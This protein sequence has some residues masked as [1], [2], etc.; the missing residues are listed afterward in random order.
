MQYLT[1]KMFFDAMTALTADITTR[2]KTAIMLEGR[3]YSFPI[4]FS[5]LKDIFLGSMN[6]IILRMHALES[7]DIVS[8]FMMTFAMLSYHRIE[9]HRTGKTLVMNL[10]LR[11]VLFL[12]KRGRAG[13]LFV[14][15]PYCLWLQDTTE[16]PEEQVLKCALLRFLKIGSF[17]ITSKSEQVNYISLIRNYNQFWRRTL[18]NTSV[19]NFLPQETANLYLSSIVDIL[20]RTRGSTNWYKFLN[21]D[22]FAP[23]VEIHAETAAQY[24][25]EQLLE[26]LVAPLEKPKTENELI[27][28]LKDVHPALGGP[29][30]SLRTTRDP[31][32]ALRNFAQHVKNLPQSIRQRIPVIV[33]STLAKTRRLLGAKQFKYFLAVRPHVL[34]A[35]TFFGAVQGGEATAFPSPIL[36]R[37]MFIEAVDLVEY[38]QLQLG[39]ESLS[40]MLDNPNAMRNVVTQL[41]ST[42]IQTISAKGQFL[43]ADYEKSVSNHA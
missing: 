43:I 41:R 5:V 34:H 19:S 26:E 18:M 11:D 23:D 12:A 1:P 29:Q 8:V 37:E 21:I 35:T 39:F 15:A 24:N 38:G 16:V 2:P 20:D 30:K 14:E 33:S 36:P 40:L 3:L 10:F 28:I 42:P 7:R 13:Q 32:A 31:L 6:R 22:V 27:H 17:A 25:Y 9:K 4:N